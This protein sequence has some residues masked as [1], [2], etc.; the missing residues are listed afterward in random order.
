M[1]TME[2]S[3]TNALLNENLT[4]S[5]ELKGLKLQLPKPLHPTLKTNQA[6]RPTEIVDTTAET[7]HH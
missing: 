1:L 6:S 7:D 3:R 2:R 5:D 4:L